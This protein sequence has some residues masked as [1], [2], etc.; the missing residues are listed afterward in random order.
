VVDGTLKA[1]IPDQKLE[2]ENLKPG[3]LSNTLKHKQNKVMKAGNL[4][5]I[6]KRKCE[7]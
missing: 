1:A 3:R 4:S 7:L 2:L 5:E 6:C